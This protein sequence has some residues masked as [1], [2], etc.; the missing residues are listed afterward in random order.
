MMC[1]AIQTRWAGSSPRHEKGAGRNSCVCLKHASPAPNR[2]PTTLSYLPQFALVGLMALDRIIPKEWFVLC[3]VHI[4]GP[5][6]TWEQH[7]ISFM[8][9]NCVMEEKPDPDRETASVQTVSWSR[10]LNSFLL[11]REIL[12]EVSVCACKSNTHA[13]FNH[14]TSFWWFS[15]DVMPSQTDSSLNK[16]LFQ[17]G[18]VC[19]SQHA[20]KTE[21]FLFAPF[22]R[23]I[24]SLLQSSEHFSSI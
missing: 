17:L 13:A 7:I 15:N 1:D 4:W 19:A 9:K 18:F 16:S 3:K 24:G 10:W 11:K 12:A 5:A 20:F 8:N 14:H 23:R 2:G 21:L 6:E 22:D